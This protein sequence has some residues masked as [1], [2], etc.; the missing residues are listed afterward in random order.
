MSFYCNSIL[1]FGSI[2]G[3]HQRF[4][5]AALNMWHHYWA[6]NAAIHCHKSGVFY[7]KSNHFVLNMLKN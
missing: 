1:I 4:V 5:N 2:R 7:V 6:L 3:E